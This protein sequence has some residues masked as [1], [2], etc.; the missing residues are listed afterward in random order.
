[1][2]EKLA[3]E[4]KSQSYKKLPLRVLLDNTQDA[5]NLGAALRVCDA[6][7]VEYL[8]CSGDEP[9]QINKKIRRVA[10]GADSHVP[11]R[12]EADLVTCIEKLKKEGFTVIALEITASSKT[13][14]NFDF[15]QFSKIALVV[16]AENLG[17]SD[18]V[19]QSCNF[20]VHIPMYGKGFSMNV[21]CALSIALFEIVRQKNKQ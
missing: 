1:M 14:Q 18:T 11:Y 13:L 21:T 9:K 15:E 16:G 10:R 7:C 2:G 19:I 8:Y 4:T 20:A 3:Y 5:S 17:I 12:Y 6:L